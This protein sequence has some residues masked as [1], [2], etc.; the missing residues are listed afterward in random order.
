LKESGDDG[1]T[2][3]FAAMSTVVGV[4]S[5]HS[6]S[7]SNAMMFV[8]CMLLSNWV[9]GHAFIRTRAVVQ[10]SRSLDAQCSSDSSAS[11][12]AGSGGAMEGD[13]IHDD[14]EFLV[15]GAQSFQL[16]FSGYSFTSPDEPVIEAIVVPE[17]WL[18]SEFGDVAK[19]QKRWEKTTDWR[20]KEGVEEILCEEQPHFHHIKNFYPHY[21]AGV[22]KEGHVVYYERPG[23]LL[24][25]LYQLNSRGIG[26]K[27]MM[28]H[29][30][31]VTEYQ[32]EILCKRNQMAKGIS[33]IDVKGVG[34]FDLMGATMDFVKKSVSVAGE[35][36]PERAK[37]VYIV[38]A[39]SIFTT[40]WAIIKKW[41]NPVTLAKVRLLSPS[42]TLEGLQES[43][44][45]SQ[46]PEHYGGHLVY[47]D[48]KD[49]ARFHSPEA[50][51]M[52]ELVRKVNNKEITNMEQ[53]WAEFG[54]GIPTGEGEAE[55]GTHTGASGTNANA[56]TNANTNMDGENIATSDGYRGSA[57]SGMNTKY[58]HLAPTEGPNGVRLDESPRAK[59]RGGGASGSA[60]GYSDG[61]PVRRGEQSN[62]R[63]YD[64][65]DNISPLTDRATPAS[66]TG[67]DST[68]YSDRH[69]YDNSNYGNGTFKDS[70]AS[71]HSA[72]R[73]LADD[74][75][76][77]LRY[78]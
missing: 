46:I 14:D 13:D 42:D 16:I 32:Y 12:S 33:I 49:G 6:L 10:A 34:I 4:T 66:S 51:G 70:P 26:I 72:Q 30:L 65:N 3:L 61:T 69:T 29:W 18:N 75:G 56:N 64:F 37:M 58:R 52:Y 22:G 43:I 19:A 20:E 44:D 77:N 25:Q 40:L 48:D 35:H 2:L 47:G 76:D 71:R 74:G 62:G 28:R 63:Q 53:V 67:G 31:F 68:N 8:V 15:T 7:T 54:L 36:Y 17:R 38:N 57:D 55:T 11:G 50:E 1:L 78:R 21:N 45:I 24:R 27:E 23:D 41:V 5:F 60:G 59:S 39:N 9:L 73:V